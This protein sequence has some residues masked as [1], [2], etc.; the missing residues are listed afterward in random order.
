MRFSIK[1][2]GRVRYADIVG[3]LALLLTVAELLV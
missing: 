1:V 2:K 3:T